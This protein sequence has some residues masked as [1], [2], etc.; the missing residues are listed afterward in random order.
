MKKIRNIIVI[1]LIAISCW[2]ATKGMKN[3]LGV[4]Y[5]T[6]GSLLIILLISIFVKMINKQDEVINQVP[7][8]TEKE[9][10]MCMLAY[11]KL[12]TETFNS[13]YVDK[14]TET[15][16]N[17]HL[18]SEQDKKYHILSLAG[19]DLEKVKKKEGKTNTIIKI[20][21]PIFTILVLG[22][23]FIALRQNLRKVLNLKDGVSIM[24][25]FS[26]KS[27]LIATTKE[28]KVGN[29]LQIGNSKVQTIE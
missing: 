10:P 11:K 23:G 5:F 9:L 1:I 6:G 14:E 12:N 25:L 13:L 28:I 24:Q 21:L 18:L 2:A 16:K 26:S 4:F 27:R 22:L 8:L 29:V 15:Y 19:E 3:F 20:C 7:G 17:F